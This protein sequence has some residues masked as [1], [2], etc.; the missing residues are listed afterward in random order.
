MS[1]AGQ[2]E[3]FPVIDLM[4]YMHAARRSGVLHF[5]NGKEIGRVCFH[6][7]HIIR[8]S[9]PKTTN[10]GDMLLLHGNLSE[11]NLKTAVHIQKTTKTN[12]PL[13]TI[14]EEMG[15]I[16]HKTLRDALIRQIG[17][18]LYEMISWEEGTFRFELEHYSFLD[19]I[20]FSPDDVIS[21]E[22]IDTQYLILEAVMTFDETRNLQEKIKPDI[23][24][25]D[26]QI[27]TSISE[28]TPESQQRHTPEAGDDFDICFSL[29]KEMILEGRE[30]D[31][32][33]SI[34]VY[35]LKILA[36]YMERAILFLIRRNELLGLGGI[37]KTSKK[38]SLNS[39]ITNMRI[40]LDADSLLLRCIETRSMFQGPPPDQQ[41]L[42]TLYERIGSP[43]ETKVTILPVAGIDRVV[44]LVYGDNG[45]TEK[46]L[47]GLE[48]LE[49]AAGQAGLIIENILLRK[50]VERNAR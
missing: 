39:E 42:R 17:Q 40:P 15:I 45:S 25:Q 10:I 19:D 33:Q 49:V 1:F 21:P 11:K 9:A 41:W 24:N 14:L 16:T 13:G 7:G 26:E 34:S 18:A 32:S 36:E 47:Q 4:Q 8:A 43:S 2:I 3:D 48:L 50:S 12:K 30:I 22:E 35:F 44:C 23:E 38:S 5:K 20:S 31:H 29:L 28:E 46:P 37:G 6:E 27:P